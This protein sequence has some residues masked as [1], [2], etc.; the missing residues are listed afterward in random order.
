[1][2]VTLKIDSPT[3]VEVS[4]ISIPM[5]GYLVRLGRLHALISGLRGPIVPT[6]DQGFAC[7]WPVSATPAT[8]TSRPP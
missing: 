1:M 8:V 4:E 7:I 2:N 5:P 6:P 3:G